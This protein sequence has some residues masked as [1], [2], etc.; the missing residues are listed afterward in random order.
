MSLLAGIELQ[1]SCWPPI[2]KNISEAAHKQ[3]TMQLGEGLGTDFL[4]DEGMGF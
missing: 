1:K 2:G 4:W 3:L